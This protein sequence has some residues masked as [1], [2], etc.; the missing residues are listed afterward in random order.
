M[1]TRVLAD[2]FASGHAAS[3]SWRSAAEAALAQ[4]G[5]GVRG[6]TLGF[7]YATDAFAE[8]FEEIVDFLRR[9][10]G[11]AHW[12]GTIGLGICASGREYLDE[13]ALALMCC[14][15]NEDAFR[16]FSGLKAPRDVARSV[17]KW[18]G[19]A[20][21]FAVV[22]A[23]PA[24]SSLTSLVRELASRT[25]S[26]F[27]VGGLTSSRTRVL[28]YADGPTEGGVSGVAFSDQVAVAT[29]LTQGCAPVG[30]EHTITDARHN[31]LISLDGR[32]ALD[33]FRED[34]GRELASN[35]SLVAGRIFAGLPVE[36]NDTGDYVVR[37]LVG[38][39]SAHKLVAI[40]ENVKPGRRIMFCRRDRG[41]ASDDLDR[42]LTSIRSGLYREPK[43]AVYFSCLGRGASLFG[44]NS[45]ELR[46]IRDRLGEVP[47]VGFFCN[48]EISHN[49]LYGY[50]GVL[51]LFL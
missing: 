22:H 32:P 13:P 29:R 43:G 5:A 11:I 8:D 17:L 6:A 27:I 23:D 14:S 31:I 36:G 33:V 42:M 28:Q 41:T 51:T 30:P 37:N 46:I 21:S 3:L 16:V 40:G 9:R 4:C 50:T 48:G 19:A 12:V 7:V 38:L 45:E 44:D 15:Y 26:G 24:T 18:D 2:Y 35:L 1:T 20:A 25:Q 34:I 39:D 47:L 49:R 10:T